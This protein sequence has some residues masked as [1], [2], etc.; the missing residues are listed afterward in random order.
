M[1][2]RSFSRLWEGFATDADAKAARDAEFRRLR[3]A[4]RRVVRSVLRNQLRPYSGLGQPD[5]RSC[6]VYMLTIAD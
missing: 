4:G 1:Q 5:G 6:H 2:Q 3:K